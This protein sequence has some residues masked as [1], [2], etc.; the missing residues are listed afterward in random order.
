MGQLLV[1]HW[2][3]AFTT[4]QPCLHCYSLISEAILKREVNL[5]VNTGGNGAK[6]FVSDFQ[7]SKK[8]LN[9]LKLS[10]KYYV[11]CL[12]PYGIKIIVIQ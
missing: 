11:N 3:S 6:L 12:L 5:N 9:Q 7:I 1:G 4:G 8:K 2:T 10:F